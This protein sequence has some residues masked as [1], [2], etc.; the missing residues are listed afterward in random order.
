MAR[1]VDL[2]CGLMLVRRLRPWASNGG[3][4]LVRTPKVYVRDS[5]IAHALL[6]LADFD[7]VIGHPAAGG[8]WEGWVI[9]IKRS[10]APVPSRGFHIAAEE[11]KVTERHVVHAGGESFPLGN[12]VK[13]STLAD[14]QRALMELE[15]RR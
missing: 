14:L 3:K 5:G 4:R 1:Y 8:S 7:D 10:S 9:E 13:A 11:L 6:G 12:G 15:P 2:L